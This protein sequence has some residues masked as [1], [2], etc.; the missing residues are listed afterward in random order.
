MEDGAVKVFDLRKSATKAQAVMS[1]DCHDKWVAQIK[2]NPQAEQVFL[3]A[4][5]DGKVKMWDLRNTTEPLSVLKR[6][7]ATDTDKV[8]ALAWNGGSQILSGGTDS[9]ISVHEL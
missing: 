4:G 8:F 5:Y 1:F 2:V 7:N 3:T 6:Q 9:H